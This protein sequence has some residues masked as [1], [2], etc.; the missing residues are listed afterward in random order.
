[1]GDCVR[2]LDKRNN[3]STSCTTN[4]NSEL[5]KINEIDE[6]NPVTYGS[7]DGDGEKIE[8]KYYEQE[9]LGSLF[10]FESNQKKLDSMNIYEYFESWKR[11]G[12]TRKLINIKPMQQSDKLEKHNNSENNSLTDV[13][14][15]Q[16]NNGNTKVVVSAKLFFD[17]NKNIEDIK[18]II[19]IFRTRYR[20]K[21]LE[22][23]KEILLDAANLVK[24]QQIILPTEFERKLTLEVKTT[25]D[26]A[27]K[28]VTIIFKK[29]LFDSFENKDQLIQS[30]LTFPDE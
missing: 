19:E 10:N 5:F 29:G 22:K 12:I 7:E 23:K 18:K 28:D 25:R 2:V 13:E 4:W 20:K 3:Y 24:E 27:V 1:M 11:T 8:G 6:T 14:E 16:F 21:M 30:Y 15:I 9:L 17:I 26:G